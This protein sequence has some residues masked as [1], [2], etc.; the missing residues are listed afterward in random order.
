VTTPE[1]ITI[2]TAVARD[3]MNR[4]RSGHPYALELLAMA[5]SLDDRAL[6]AQTAAMLRRRAGR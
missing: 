3:L 2:D 4:R 6:A 5:D 1:R